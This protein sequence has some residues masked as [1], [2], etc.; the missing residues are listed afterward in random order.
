MRAPR[1]GLRDSLGAAVGAICQ[2]A[3]KP[4]V[5]IGAGGSASGFQEGHEP[6]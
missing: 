6:Q 1:R 4:Q 5:S 3:I 2:G